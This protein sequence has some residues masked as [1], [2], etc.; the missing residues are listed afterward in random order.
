MGHTRGAKP[1]AP[2]FG[3]APGGVY[4][5]VECYHR[6]G[7]LLP[8]PFT[9]TGTVTRT[10]LRRFAFCC[11]FRGLTPPRDY[12]APCPVEPGLSSMPTREDGHRGC[13]ADSR[14]AWWAYR[15]GCASN[16]WLS[17]GRRVV[18]LRLLCER[19]NARS[20][21][22]PELYRPVIQRSPLFSSDSGGELCRLGHRQF[23]KKYLEH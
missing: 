2:L 20:L 19:P 17:F 8:H 16:G 11:T 10:A 6:R 1:P 12:L 22:L 4:R 18:I 7:A 5:A 15:A 23:F 13:L 3:L 21:S 14:R 9:L